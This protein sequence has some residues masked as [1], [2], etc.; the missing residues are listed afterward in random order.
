MYG[1]KVREHDFKVY[2][3]TIGKNI[4]NSIPLDAA[5][6]YQGIA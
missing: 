3:D 6:G 1:A 4:N 2:K 5:L